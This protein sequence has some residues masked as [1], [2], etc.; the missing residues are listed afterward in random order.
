MLAFLRDPLGSFVG[1]DSAGPAPKP[2]RIQVKHGEGL[3]IARGLL[4]RGLV[5]GL[6]Q[7]ELLYINGEPLLNGVFGVGKGKFLAPEPGEPKQLGILRLI[8]NLSAAA[9]QSGRA[10]YPAPKRS[11][12][13]AGSPAPE[14][15]TPCKRVRAGSPAPL[16]ARARPP[17][18]VGGPTRK[19]PTFTSKKPEQPWANLHSPAY[20]NRNCIKEC[21]GFGTFLRCD[22]SARMGCMVGLRCWQAAGAL[23]PCE[24]PCPLGQVC[25]PSGQLRAAQQPRP[26]QCAVSAMR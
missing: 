9:A 22:G 25:L 13:R 2:G 10:G 20:S 5:V 17:Q 14:R 23:V 24:R 6:R 11:P 7:E 21:D 12:R 19:R 4:S 3:A 8:M 16:A 26:T 15:S 1:L 18:E